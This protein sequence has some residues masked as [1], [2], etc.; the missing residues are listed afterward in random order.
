[1][2]YVN[3]ATKSGQKEIIGTI[4]SYSNNLLGETKKIKE[5]FSL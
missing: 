4:R 3:Q 2:N 1:M 5:K